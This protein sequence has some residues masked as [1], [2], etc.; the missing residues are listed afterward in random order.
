MKEIS[1]ILFVLSIS[2]VTG[3]QHFIVDG[4]IGDDTN[5][6]EDPDHPFK[7]IQ[8]CVDE[9]VLRNNP[10]D[11]CQIREGRYHEEVYVNGLLGTEAEQIVI[12][13]YLDERPII[14]GTVPIQ[15]DYWDFDEDTGICSATIDNDIFALFFDDDLMTAARWPNALWS[16]KTC[17]DNRFWGKCDRHSVNG[18]IIDDGVSGLAESGINATGSM[19]VLNIGSFNTYARPILF[20]EPGSNNFTYNHTMGEVHWTNNHDQ[21]YFEASLQ[22]LD[23]PEEWFYDMY[24]KKLYFIPPSIAS[25]MC[26]DS[27]STSL[28]GRVVDYGMEVTNSSWVTVA[29]MTFHSSSLNAHS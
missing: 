5:S 12:K 23:I 21:Y 15:P 20:H 9:L 2:L 19:G 11:Q 29:N 1:W 3:C 7:T 28:R 13:G 4:T 18:F 14:D 24:T 22:L 6:G 8:R 25:G 26:P 16:D 10:G 17:F 27:E